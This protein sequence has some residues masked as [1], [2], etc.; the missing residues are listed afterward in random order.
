MIHHG[1]CLT[2][3]TAMP[4]ETVDLIYADPPF[5]P[6]APFADCWEGTSVEDFVEWMRPRVVAMRRLLNPSGS[7]YLHCDP[8]TSHYLKVMMDTIFGQDQFQN[9]IVWSYGL[10]GSSWK[11]FSRKHDVILFYTRS[12]NWFFN[13][14]MVPAKSQRL[15]GKL[16]GATDVWAIPSINNMARERTGYPTQKPLALLERIIRASSNPD[17]VVLDPFC[18]SGTTLVA[19]QQLGRRWIGIDQSPEAV[20]VATRRLD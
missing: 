7:F 6:G 11:R 3:M 17:D 15:K 20:A 14:P 1:D 19:A 8:S 12:E 2:V 16:K 13:K 9:E 5:G 18:G 4:P 10:G